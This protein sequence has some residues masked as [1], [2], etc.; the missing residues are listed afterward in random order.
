METALYDPGRGYYPRRSP[1]EDFY[2]APELHPAFAQ[3]LAREIFLRLEAVAAAEPEAPLF[4]VEM[5]SGNGRLAGQILDALRRREDGWHKRVRYVLVERVE[6]LLL[7]SVARLGAVSDGVLGYSRLEDVPPCCGV[8]LSNELVDALPFHVLEKKDGR[9]REV[10]VE[11]GASLTLRE[12][13]TP[14]LARHAEAA[15]TWLEEG[16]RHALSLAARDW[17]RLVATK[18][19]RG[20]V[21]SVDYGD[22]PASPV[23]NAP[24]FFFRH[25]T[26]SDVLAR[27]GRQDLTASVDFASL[28]E[29]GRRHGLKDVRFCSLSR[30]LIERGALESLAAGDSASAYAERNRVKTLLHPGGM[31]EAFKVLIQ[32]KIA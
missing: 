10:F 32:E 19:Q 5:G 21:L 7:E 18:L 22:A 29:E 30:F 9:V 28:I 24:R 15:A 3:A 2:T 23:A 20:A 16:Q 27:A 8:F 12:P 26:G 11:G 13:S 14:E 4:I 25:S 1:G 17:M 6:H 31:G